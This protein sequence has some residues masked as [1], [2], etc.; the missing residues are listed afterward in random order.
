M[1]CVIYAWSEGLLYSAHF[2]IQSI[3]THFPPK[4]TLLCRFSY[5]PRPHP[6]NESMG[7]YLFILHISACTLAC[8]F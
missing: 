2:C 4:F 1:M 6:V 7:D 5:F 8:S 3:Y